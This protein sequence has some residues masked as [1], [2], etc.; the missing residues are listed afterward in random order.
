[1]PV[2]PPA[3]SFL[4][5]PYFIADWL[6]PII[7]VDHVPSELWEVQMTTNFGLLNSGAVVGTSLMIEKLSNKQLF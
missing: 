6:Y 1:V 2:V 4:L 5:P 7:H 3:S